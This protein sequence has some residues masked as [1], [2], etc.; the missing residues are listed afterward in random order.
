MSA[1]IR[2]TGVYRPVDGYIIRFGEYRPLVPAIIVRLSADILN[3][4]LLISFEGMQ[5]FS[6]CAESSAAQ[7]GDGYSTPLRIEL[8]DSLFPHTY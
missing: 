3:H 7:N 1:G 2:L 5:I 6:P 8:S 4:I